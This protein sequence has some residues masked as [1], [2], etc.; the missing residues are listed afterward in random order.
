[1]GSK[2]NNLREIREFEAGEDGWILDKAIETL[3]DDKE[4]FDEW[5]ERITTSN[6]GVHCVYHKGSVENA[7]RCIDLLC[8]VG[9][10]RV[11]NKSRYLYYQKYL[12]FP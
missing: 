2:E 3:A 8:Y 11:K 10:V 12:R 5:V 6:Y 4:S 9:D 1:M 7:I